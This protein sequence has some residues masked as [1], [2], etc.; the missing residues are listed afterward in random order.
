MKIKN[1]IKLLNEYNDNDMI[2]IKDDD[3]TFSEANAVELI[4]ISMDKSAVIGGDY[5]Y[6]KDGEFVVVFTNR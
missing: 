6:D 2:Y 1:A 4:P 5:T 3:G